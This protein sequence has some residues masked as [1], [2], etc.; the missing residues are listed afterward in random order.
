[1]KFDT[2]LLFASAAILFLI[3]N[4]GAQAA[5]CKEPDAGSDKAAM[6]SPPLAEIVMGPAQ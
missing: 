6:F 2:R 3:L 1:M 4:G 5:D